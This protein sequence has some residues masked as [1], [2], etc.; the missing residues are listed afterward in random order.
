MEV[1][2]RRIIQI[3]SADNSGDRPNITIFFTI[4]AVAVSFAWLGV[5]DASKWKAGVALYILGRAY[6]ERNFALVGS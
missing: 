4:L 3:Q 6:Y 1:R 5:E 2:L